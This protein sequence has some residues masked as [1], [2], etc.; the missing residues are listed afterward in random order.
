[1]QV[2]FGGTKN[3][4]LILEPCGLVFAHVDCVSFVRGD[5]DYPMCDGELWSL[6][7]I[8]RRGTHICKLVFAYINYV[9]SIR[10]DRDCPMY[11]EELLGL[12]VF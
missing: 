8:S 12:L 4:T 5:H 2:L 3:P 7:Q 11:E 1:M 9:S 10:G 6:F